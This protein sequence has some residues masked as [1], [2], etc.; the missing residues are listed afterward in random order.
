M[1]NRWHVTTRCERIAKVSGQAPRESNAAKITTS[2]I[3]PSEKSQTRAG[4]DP[5]LATS[6]LVV[7][8][9]HMNSRN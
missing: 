4:V 5:T 3:D 9:V 1:G 7:I 2:L 8:R 6:E